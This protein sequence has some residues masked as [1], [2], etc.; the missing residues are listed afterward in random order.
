VRW[1]VLVLP[2]R[3]GRGTRQDIACQ[4]MA[5]QGATMQDRVIQRIAAR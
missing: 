1:W 3:P 4:G 2:V 5:M